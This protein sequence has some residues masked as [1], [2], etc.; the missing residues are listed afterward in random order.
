M[1]WSALPL[2]VRRV[3]VLVALGALWEILPALTGANPLLF[4]P[5]SAALRAWWDGIISGEI[6]LVTQ[7]SLTVLLVG[8][9]LGIGGAILLAIFGIFTTLGRDVLETLTG[10]FNPLPA[11]AV[12][13]LAL[14]WFG[15]G[16]KSLLFVIFHAVVWPLAIS[17]FTGFISVPRIFLMVG[18]NYELRGPHLVWRVYVPA[19]LPHVVSGLKIAFAFAW[20]TLVAAELVFGV[21]GGQGGLGWFI[22]RARYYM[23]TA[24]VFAG[25][26]TIV[27]VGLLVENLVFRPLEGATIRR[28]GMSV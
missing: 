14:L 1:K 2:V 9:A 10:M 19:A 27:L 7:R 22:Y 21:I 23:E 6:L 15:I 13:P 11:I 4:P 26:A 16:D 3:V 24:Q 12:F 17:I 28:W 20:R 18:E 5:A 8:L 25:L